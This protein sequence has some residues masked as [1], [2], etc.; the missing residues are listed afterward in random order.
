MVSMPTSTKIRGVCPQH[1]SLSPDSVPW[2]QMNNPPHPH[3][4]YVITLMVEVLHRPCGLFTP[5]GIGPRGLLVPC[6]T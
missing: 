6:H 5:L 1:V 4:D 2:Q 3:P